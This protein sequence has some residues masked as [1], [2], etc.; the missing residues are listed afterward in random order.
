M[1]DWA[2]TN[3]YGMEERFFYLFVRFVMALCVWR[4]ESLCKKRRF[5]DGNIIKL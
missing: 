1:Y 5:F 4:I 2:V 3:V